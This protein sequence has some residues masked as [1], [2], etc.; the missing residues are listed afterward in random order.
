MKGSITDLNPQEVLTVAIFVEKRNCSIYQHYARMFRGSDEEIERTFLEMAEEEQRHE[1]DLTAVYRKRFGDQPCPLTDEDIR[2]VVESPALE[3]GEAFIW[4]GIRIE[5]AL[6]IGLR[7]EQQ[8]ADFYR[9]LAEMVTD[10]DLLALFVELAGVEVGHEEVLARR[11]A[12][13][14]QKARA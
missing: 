6:R 14:E 13:L 2:E 1:E 3:N 4:S 12:R 10:L 8:A 11:L 7:A 9:Q 5:D